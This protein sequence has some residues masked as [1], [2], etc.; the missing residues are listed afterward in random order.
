MLTWSPSH[1]ISLCMETTLIQGAIV[2]QAIQG[3]VLC[4]R[5]GPDWTQAVASDI[6]GLETQENQTSFGNLGLKKCHN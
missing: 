1:R 3:A 2:S 6:V 4:P 5:M